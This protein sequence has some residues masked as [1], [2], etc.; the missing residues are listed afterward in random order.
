MYQIARRLLAIALPLLP[1]YQFSVQRE[2]KEISQKMFEQLHRTS[3]LFRSSDF[4]IGTTL[5]FSFLNLHVC[6]RITLKR[7]LKQ[8]VACEFENLSQYVLGK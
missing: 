8:H 1:I 5:L 4:Q 6:Y 3:I 7:K 2:Y